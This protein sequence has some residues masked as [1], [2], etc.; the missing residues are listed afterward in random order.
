M[1]TPQPPS[2][3]WNNEV[4]PPISQDANFQDSTQYRAYVDS[5]IRGTQTLALQAL[6]D[7]GGG[8]GTGG[9][10]NVTLTSGA[11]ANVS[12]GGLLVGLI[13]G[14]TAAFSISGIATSASSKAGLPLVLINTTAYQM[15][16]TNEDSAS[17]ASN[18]IRCL[19]GNGGPL[20]LKPFGGS[21]TLYY[22]ASVSNRWY[23]VS[24]GWETQ[25]PLVI[26]A[27]EYGAVGG[28]GTT[29]SYA[30]IQAALDSVGIGSNTTVLLPETSTKLTTGTIQPFTAYGIS[31]PLVQNDQFVSGGYN[32]LGNSCKRLRG[33]S[34]ESVGLIPTYGVVGSVFDPDWMG[35]MVIQGSYS[36]TNTYTL[37]TDTGMT[38]IASGFNAGL[39]APLWYHL[40]SE[41][42]I[43]H[44]HGLAAF[45]WEFWINPGTDVPSLGSSYTP[46]SSSGALGTGLDSHTSFLLQRLNSG[47]VVTVAATLV[48]TGGTFVATTSA[49]HDLTAS[50][51]QHVTVDYDGAH[52]R[53]FINGVQ[54]LNNLSGGTA[55]AAMTVSATGTIIQK[56]YEIFNNG[57]G[58]MSPWP[59]GPLVLASGI[60]YHTGKCRMSSASRYTAPFTP[61]AAAVTCDSNTKY[62]MDWSAATPAQNGFLGNTS[63]GRISTAS[64]WTI[65]RTGAQWS[66]RPRNG[67]PA[68]L[69]V[70][71]RMHISENPYT[72]HAELSDLTLFGNWCHAVRACAQLHSYNHD[73]RIVL[74]EQGLVYDNFSYGCTYERIDFES[75]GGGTAGSFNS[76]NILH[77]VGCQFMTHGDGIETNACVTN[78]HLVHTESDCTIRKC[79]LTGSTQGSFAMM[80][81]ASCVA[82]GAVVD[83]ENGAQQYASWLFANMPSVEIIGGWTGS[84]NVNCPDFKIGTVGS[85]R[86][87]TTSFAFNA[88]PV[89]SFG[90]NKNNGIPVRWEGTSSNQGTVIIDP[91][92]PGPVVVTAQEF[93]GV[94]PITFP[95]DADYTLAQNP[96]D[97]FW[98]NYNVTAGTIST[99]CTLTWPANPGKIYEGRNNNAQSVQLTRTGS[100][101]PVTVTTGS[102]WKVQDNGTDLVSM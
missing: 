97:A 79:F 13:G 95:S 1:G 71:M 92:H 62:Y 18:R 72:N 6:Q 45:N 25:S 17:S 64:E 11:N 5:Q 76:W 87:A 28:L 46:V 91:S 69:P 75:M 12:T 57:G 31:Q 47:G 40:L 7:G 35:P 70:W 68:G 44:I 81:N 23:A 67:N 80:G 9:Q 82:T 39:S 66:S 56:W 38:C 85:G 14:P 55:D 90:T 98:H 36:D 73:L 59:L 20:V 27:R 24:R 100:S 16:L 89:F 78:W 22:D 60:S 83:D 41:Y 58:V 26:D 29:D 88:Q 101:S 15:T 49:G 74:C 3:I 65:C 50:T 54:T 53:L 30:A 10:F 52:L 37:V 42:D 2:K 34:R 43:G 99:T 84:G 77:G 21:A 33:E 8:G 93:F 102:T 61:S 63:T 94:H 19:S 51:L 86:F 32:T 96:Q 48:T 4:D